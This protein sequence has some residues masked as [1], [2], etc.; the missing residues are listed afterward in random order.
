MP[1]RPLSPGLKRRLT[2]SEEL[3]N[4]VPRARSQTEDLGSDRCGANGEGPSP[5]SPILGS[6]LTPQACMG[7]RGLV[8]WCGGG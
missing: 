7:R 5:T 4:R 3:W 8:H 6:A 1:M 2:D